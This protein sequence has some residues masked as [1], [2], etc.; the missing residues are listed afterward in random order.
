MRVAAGHPGIQP[1]AFEKFGDPC[2]RL[3]PGPAAV[4]DEGFSDLRP[5]S[6]ARI[7]RRVRVLEDHLQPSSGELPLRARRVAQFLPLEADGSA[8]RGKTEGC[9]GD[10]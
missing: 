3:A 6:L 5:D 8:V 1:H 2:R 7:E 9:A 10:G 4:H